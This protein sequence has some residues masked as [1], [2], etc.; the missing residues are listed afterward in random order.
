MGTIGSWCAAALLG[1]ASALPLQAVAQPVAIAPAQGPAQA[2]DL[3]AFVDGV[4]QDAL[5][6]DHIAGATVAIVRGDQVLL[7]KGYGS[8]D[9]KSRTPVDPERTLFRIGSLSKTFAWIAL[10]R[11]VEKGR[12]DLDAPVNTYLPDDLKIPDDGFTRPIRVRDL[13]SHTAGFEDIGLGHML[14]GTGAKVTSLEAYLRDHR[15]RRVREPGVTPAYSNYGAALGGYIAARLAGVDFP[16]LAEREI[17]SPLG[18]ADTTFREPYPAAA[19]LAAPMAPNLAGRVSTAYSWTGGAFAPH[20]FEYV[21]RVGPAGSGSTTARDMATYMQMLLS[22]GSLGGATIFGPDT[23]RAFRTPLLNTPLS[24]GWAHGF[25]ISALPGG[26][27]GY[28]HPGATGFFL[29]NMVLEPTSG[30]GVFIATNTD[31][32]RA[33]TTRLPEMIIQRLQGGTPAMKPGDPA[34][35]KQRAALS[36]YYLTTR[37]AYEGLEKFVSLLASAGGTVSVTPGGYLITRTGPVVQSWVPDGEPGR[38][39]N[40]AGDQRI[41]FQYGPD[42][43]ASGYRPSNGMSQMERASLIQTPTVLQALAGLTLV[44]GIAAW[45]GQF[46]RRRGLKPTAAQRAASLG[47]LMVSGVWAAAFIGVILWAVSAG[48]REAL[49]YGFPGPFLKGA[50]IAALIAAVGSALLLLSAPLTWRGGGS[51]EAWTLGRKIRH[52]LTVAIFTAFGAVLA[53]WGALTP[54][55]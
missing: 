22:Q 30:V 23:A 8:A 27:K 13:M 46:T 40:A 19:G 45:V 54:W 21:S 28:G 48:Q 51:E 2:A 14:T 15:P 47:V 55:A 41:T 37:R 10:M 3:Q 26:Q 33:L 39:V 5:A 53:A 35:A 49:V 18:M 29:S 25:M 44:A 16:T 1:A 38:F 43:R 4:V 32:G 24:N 34:T 20:G 6:A 50:S 52:S 11:E 36:G 7:L 12:V 42:G 31:T 17:L 9:I